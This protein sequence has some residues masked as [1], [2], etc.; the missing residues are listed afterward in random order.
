MVYCRVQELLNEISVNS[1]EE[2]MM[3]KLIITSSFYPQICVEDE[4]NSSKTVSEKVYHTKTKNFVFL[5]PL[6]YFSSNPEILELHVDDIEEPP[7]GK[8][9]LHLKLISYIIS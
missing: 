1:F 4:F 2:I 3:I 7:A 5:K 8:N 9:F 6:S